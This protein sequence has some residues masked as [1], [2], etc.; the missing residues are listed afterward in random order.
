MEKEDTLGGHGGPSLWTMRKGLV[1]IE[2]EWP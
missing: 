1:R 2:E